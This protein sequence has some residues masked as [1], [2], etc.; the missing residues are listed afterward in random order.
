MVN[1]SNREVFIEEITSKLDFLILKL[2]VE[3][4]EDLSNN[5]II[6]KV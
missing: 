3:P 2:D 5:L 4:K 1:M 6:G